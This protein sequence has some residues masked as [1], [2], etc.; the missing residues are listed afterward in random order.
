[1]RYHLGMAFGT[2]VAARLPDDDIE[3]IDAL[4]AE[5]VFES[6]AEAIRVA[7]E[8]LL[9]AERQRRIG[10]AIVDGY[11]RIPETDE[12]L[13]IAEANTRRLIEEEPW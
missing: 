7:V 2:Q 13:A 5:G 1:M 8:R 12:E 11:R 6:R 3:G 9:E 4:V 10:D